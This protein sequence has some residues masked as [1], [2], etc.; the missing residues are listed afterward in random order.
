MI[1]FLADHTVDDPADIAEAN[2]TL[3][4]LMAQQERDDKSDRAL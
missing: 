2:E 4:D 1:A 3:A